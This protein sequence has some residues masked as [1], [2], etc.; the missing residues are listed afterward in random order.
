LRLCIAFV[1]TP[2]DS[3]WIGPKKIYD[4]RFAVLPK[5]RDVLTKGWGVLITAGALGLGL[6]L[7][8]AGPSRAQDKQAAPSQPQA[9]DTKEFNEASAAQKETNDSKRL[10]D[11]DLWKKDYPTTEL[12]DAR[13]GMYLITYANLKM[14]RQAFDMA[15][16]ILKT[17]PNDPTALAD[18]IYFVT[19]IKPAPTTADLDTGE[20]DALTVLDNPAVFGNKPANM[21]DQQ[22][23]ATQ[24]QAKD[25]AKRVLLAIYTSRD[26]N[27][28]DKRLVDELTKLINRDPNLPNA[29]Y[30]LGLAMQRILKAENRPQDQPPMFWQFARAIDSTVTGP[31]ALPAAVK[32]GAT[33]YLTDAYTAFHGS[34]NGLQDLLAAAKSS[35]FP[36]AGFKI[37]SVV[38]IAKAQVAADEA[39]RA[40]DPLGVFWREDIKGNL[41]KN[42]PSFFDNIKGAELPGKDPKDTS[43]SPAP[44]YFTATIVSMTPANRPK[45]ILVGIEKPDVADAKLVF[46]TALPG[47]ME[48]G[49]KIRFKGLATDYSPDPF[50]ITFMVD[51][52]EDM[53]GSWT[54]KNVTN[55][56]GRGAG[57][58]GGTKAPPKQQ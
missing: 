18:A 15:Q 17:K 55:R 2:L 25:L 34:A 38:D 31:N 23:A 54:G 51:E 50:M 41:M 56:G 35:P 12:V 4:R 46:E 30:A 47:K 57:T 33:K 40:A 48:P 32:T 14:A 13:D 8:S 44:R 42:G 1:Y 11:L 16:E 37:D 36:P 43:D 20:K 53:D 21:N 29:D 5:K 3:T 10:E 49:E 24:T 9:K 7:G 22:W 39:A 58:K 26:A 45:E 52:K 6:F 27:K 19:A 28:D